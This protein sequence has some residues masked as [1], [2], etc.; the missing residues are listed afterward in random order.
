[1]AT[2][3]VINNQKITDMLQKI[4]QLGGTFLVDINKMV[5][6][7]ISP[8]EPIYVGEGKTKKKL[9]IYDTNIQDPLACILN[10]FSETSVLPQEQLLFYSGIS[11]VVSQWIQRIMIMIIDQCVLLNEDKNATV[12]PKLVQYLTPFISKVD[13][14]LVAEMEKIKGAGHKSFA[15][16]HY[17]RTKKCSTLIIGLEDE[18]GDYQKQFPTSQ[19]RKRSWNVLKDMIRFILKVPEDKKIS[20]YYTCSTEKVECPRFTTYMD[21]WV[22]VWECLN[23]Y[24]DWTGDHHSEPETIE[25]LKEHFK[26]I[27]VY[28][29][30]VTWLK[31]PAIS[32]QGM[33]VPNAD[34][35][36]SNAA[37]G[38]V[39]PTNPQ[40]EKKEPSWKITNTPSVGMASSNMVRVTPSKPQPSWMITNNNFN[41]GNNYNQGYMNYNSCNMV[42]IRSW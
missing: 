11:T 2:E 13:E 42:K 18:T 8:E 38:V 10:P 25:A 34:N 35:A 3:K 23:P 5:H 39:I 33:S 19:I 17:N 9:Y 16:I 31:Q 36:V 14:K 6:Y 28:R 29:E 37:G 30:C 41:P 20:E 1:M 12:D 32:M 4:M 7:V 27:P 24:M 21:V 22:R 40:P 15:N 26:N